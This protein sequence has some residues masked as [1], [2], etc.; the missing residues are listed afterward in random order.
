MSLNSGSILVIEV[1][2]DGTSDKIIATGNANLGGVLRIS[3]EAGTYNA[4][5]YFL[6]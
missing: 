1:N 5:T 2:A 3:P 4:S 6:L